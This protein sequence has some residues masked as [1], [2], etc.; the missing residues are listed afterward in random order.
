RERPGKASAVPACRWCHPRR[1]HH[2]VDNRRSM[3]RARWKYMADMH[4]PHRLPASPSPPLCTGVASGTAGSLMPA[5]LAAAE[6]WQQP[7]DLGPHR[8]GSRGKKRLMARTALGWRIR[9]TGSAR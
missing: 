6:R 5:R 4:P 8:G 9:R 7:V 3:R 1:R 2:G